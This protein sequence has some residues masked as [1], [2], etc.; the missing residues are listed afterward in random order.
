MPS[1]E[2]FTGPHERLGQR[3]DPLHGPDRP[4]RGDRDAA[5]SSTFRDGEVVERPR[6][7]RAR[8]TSRR[9]CATDAGARFLGELGIGTN[10]GIDRPSGHMLLDEKMAGTVHL[11]LGRSY[12]ET[13]GHESSALHWDL[14][15]DLRDGGRLSADGEPIEA[16]RYATVTTAHGIQ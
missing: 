16:R 9:R 12:P 10:A 1:G 6:A 3:H 11:A 15:C 8:P 4:A 2:V 14:I 13:G 5:S 7:S